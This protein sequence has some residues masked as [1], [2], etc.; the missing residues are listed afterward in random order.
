MTVAK[1][2][3]RMKFGKALYRP[4]WLSFHA[5]LTTSQQRRHY[6]QVELRDRQFVQP[7]SCCVNNKDQLSPSSASPGGRHSHQEEVTS[8]QVEDW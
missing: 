4:R 3:R 8:C 2:P 1:T 7:T 5:E 6:S